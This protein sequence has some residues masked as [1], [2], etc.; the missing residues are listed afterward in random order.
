MSQ[1]L[2]D[3]SQRQVVHSITR[4]TA[5]LLAGS[6]LFGQTNPARLRGS[7]Q[8]Q[9]AHQF[10]NEPDVPVASMESQPPQA[11]SNYAGSNIIT[12]QELNH[13]VPKRARKELEK[14]ETARAKHRTDE[15]ID[16]FKQAILIDPEF[17]AARNNLAAIYLVAANPESA[18]TQLEEA[19]T[20]DPNNPTLLR[21][22]TVGYVMMRKFDAAERAARLRVR[23]DR[24]SGH[25]SLLLG[26]VLIQQ[27]KFTGEALRCFERVR[28]EYPL[29]HLLA[30]MVLIE[31]RSS[32]R[33]KAEIQ[34]Y[35]SSGQ[36]E[37]RAFA[38]RLLALIDQGEQKSAS[39]VSPTRPDRLS[40][41]SS[42]S[43]ERVPANPMP[44]DD[45]PFRVDP[46]L[47]G[48]KLS[49]P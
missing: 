20:I 46:N 39:S 23:L 47:P 36:Q 6:A 41:A 22:L 30:A 2:P 25:A 12:I 38:T 17:V 16:H 24:T 4:L 14:A 8:R 21:N 31:H 3:H 49:T 45:Q 28:D 13:S 26:F 48:L 44:M 34:T 19:V 43:S 32:E 37:L 10:P 5:V 29:A 42:V 7:D 15:A 40:P 27:R 33:A 1:I 9:T 11:G 35:L 18:V